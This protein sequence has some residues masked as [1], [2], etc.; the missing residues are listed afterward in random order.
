MTWA[1][2]KSAFNHVYHSEFG[3]AAFPSVRQLLKFC[4]S[5][6]RSTMGVNLCGAA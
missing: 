1:I 4:D 3:R 5:M 2:R 6:W